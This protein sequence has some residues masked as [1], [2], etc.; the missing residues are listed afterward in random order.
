M[1]N[2]LYYHR[3]KMNLTQADVA[4]EMN[5]HHITYK[6]YERGETEIKLSDA[7]MVADKLN[8]TLDQLY[9]KLT[10]FEV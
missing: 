1:R 2:K 3:R 8:L 10:T 5:V 7:K 4:K 6:N 9:E